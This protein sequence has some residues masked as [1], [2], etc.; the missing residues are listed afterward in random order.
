MSERSEAVR[1]AATIRRWV[2]E[3][4]LAAN[5]GHIGSSL[6]I[7]DIVAALW[8]EV[9]R[10]PG[11]D[12][13]DR[14]RFVL[15]VGHASMLM[16]SLLHLSG[17]DVSDED[18]RNFRQWGS[19]TAGHPE[20]GHASGIETTTGP[21]G[22][23][24]GGKTFILH[25]AHEGFARKTII[26]CRAKLVD[27]ELEVQALNARPRHKTCNAVGIGPRRHRQ[28]DACHIAVLDLG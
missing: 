18:I 16:Y 7:A 20:Y 13:P 28:S 21:L 10:D 1:C 3:R 22:Q 17:Y 9:L 14:D 24:Q 27:V 4:S 25:V 8:A 15:S 12:D 26:Q 5:V 2:I 23:G 6:S 19:I 11:T